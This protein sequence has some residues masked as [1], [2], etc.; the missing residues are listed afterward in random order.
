MNLYKSI[1]LFIL[2]LPF[3]EG[4]VRLLQSTASEKESIPRILWM[5]IHNVPGRDRPVDKMFDEN[6]STIIQKYKNAWNNDE[7]VEVHTL[8]TE[9]CKD[10]ISKVPIKGASTDLLQYFMD[11]DPSRYSCHLAVLFL[12]GGYYIQRTVEVIEPFI[13]PPGVTLAAVTNSDGSIFHDSFLAAAPYNSLIY[14][15]LKKYIAFAKG[16]YDR[17]KKS[18]SVYGEIMHSSYM[19]VTTINPSKKSG[20]ALLSL[21]DLNQLRGQQD[22][23]KSVKMQDAEGEFCNKVVVDQATKKVYYYLLFP[24]ASELCGKVTERTEAASVV[25]E[26]K[27]EVMLD[28]SQSTG[29]DASTEADP[30]IP[31]KL[32]FFSRQGI[33][34]GSQVRTHVQKH[35]HNIQNTVDSYKNTWDMSSIEYEILDRQ[36]C[37]DAIIRSPMMYSSEK[38]IDYFQNNY[39]DLFDFCRAIVLHEHGGYSFNEELEVVRKC[40]FHFFFI[41]FTL[42]TLPLQNHTLQRIMI[43]HLLESLIQTNF[44]FPPLW[45]RCHNIQ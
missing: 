13:P 18:T 43:F 38:L 11:K 8:S 24:G 42:L 25:E 20:V 37:V 26:K 12:Y 27:S 7:S 2:T 15:A 39:D 40:D 1:L 16:E 30:K 17:Q 35:H 32:W 41:L 10:A 45:L 28:K 36:A 21:Q 19:E 3:I 23:Y 31:H 14:R 6:I 44:F 33:T 9:T 22:E 29:S 34:K 5:H 4:S